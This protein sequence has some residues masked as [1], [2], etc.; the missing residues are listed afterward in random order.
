MSIT[1]S[2]NQMVG[3][4]NNTR[5]QSHINHNI[6]GAVSFSSVVADDRLVDVREPPNRDR[7]IT[8]ASLTL[9]HLR[10]H[11]LVQHLNYDASVIFPSPSCPPAHLNVLSRGY[12][13]SEYA[14]KGHEAECTSFSSDCVR[15]KTTMRKVS[16]PPNT[17]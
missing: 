17:R 3:R 13:P 12:P 11:L 8:C 2:D 10:V 1:Y 15:C 4:Q 14:G 9:G 6:F 16:L 7:R 5:T